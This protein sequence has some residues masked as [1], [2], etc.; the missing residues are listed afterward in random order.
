MNLILGHLVQSIIGRIFSGLFDIFC[1][2]LVVK[3]FGI[4]EFEAFG[5]FA[6]MLSIS[7]EGNY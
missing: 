4:N 1:F 5:R 7:K 3:C 2:W 6:E